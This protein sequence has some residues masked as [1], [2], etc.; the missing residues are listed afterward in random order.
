MDPQE[1][2][3]KRRFGRIDCWITPK[4]LD[5]AAN[6]SRFSGHSAREA[7]DELDQTWSEAYHGSGWH[8]RAEAAKKNKQRFLRLGW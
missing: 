1:F 8:I 5:A 6:M 7:Q 3:P 2:T 4:A